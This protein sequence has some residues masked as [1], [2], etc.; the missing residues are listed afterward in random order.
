MLFRSILKER[1]GIPLLIKSQDS[2]V[3]GYLIYFKS[4]SED[5]AYRRII[6]IEPEEVY[7]W[8]KIKV[9]DQILSNALLG[10]RE[11]RGSSDLEHVEEWNGKNDPFFVQGLNEVEEITFPITNGL[12]ISLV[13]Y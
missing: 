4:G 5:I 7:R 2:K 8:S 11:Q 12:H 3:K 13:S 9:N 10:K 1:D 6:E